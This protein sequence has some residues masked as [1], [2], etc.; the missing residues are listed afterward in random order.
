[1]GEQGRQARRLV[2]FNGIPDHQKIRYLMESAQ[3]KY[4]I[5][6]GYLRGFDTN[7]EPSIGETS[8]DLP[9]QVDVSQLDQS[10]DGQ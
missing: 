10:H 4:L 9:S 2:Y 1:M 6:G 5:F 8:Q 3:S 7:R